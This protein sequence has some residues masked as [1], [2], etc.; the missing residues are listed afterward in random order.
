[1]HKALGSI[2]RGREEGR[3]GGREERKKERKRKRKKTKT[4]SKGQFFIKTKTSRKKFL[5]LE[6]NLQ[7]LSL[8]RFYP[9]LIED[10]FHR[11]WHI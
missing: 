6:T 3:E 1:M 5:Y 8:Q 7:P 4:S 2:P 9:V 10:F 11:K